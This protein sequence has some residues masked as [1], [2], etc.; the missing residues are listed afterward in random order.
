MFKMRKYLLLAMALLAMS[1]SWAQ[2]S[3]AIEWPSEGYYTTGD[4]YLVP[5]DTAVRFRALP[6]TGAE[7]WQW[8]LPG[9][10]PSVVEA[11][12][13]EVV[14]TEEGTFDVSLEALVGGTQRQ[15]SVE[16]GIQAGGANYVWNISP[17]ETATLETISLAWFGFYGGTNSLGMEKFAEFFHAPLQPALIDSV[18][19]R[20]GAN[21]VA[22]ANA[23]LTLSIAAA[24][25]KG[26]PG[27]TL[28]ATML[29]AADINKQLGKPTFFRFDQP[30]RVDGPFFV[31]IEG[32]PNA[33]GDGV[34]I[35]CVRREVGQ[36]CTAFHLLA[37]EDIHYQPMGTFTWY[38]NVDD[39]TSLA[40]CPWLRY[41]EVSSV[42]NRVGGMTAQCTFDGASLRVPVATAHL[43]VFNAAGLKVL[44]LDNPPASI[45]LASLPSGTYL[46]R[47]DGLTLKIRR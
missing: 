43:D 8:N 25:E 44:S 7:G 31:V 13:A 3:L 10:T 24:D 46:V 11:Q 22:T 5:L 41:E 23:E 30:V 12:E 15:V 29:L 40:I 16:Q 18:A 45:S 47:A 20:F 26:M 21:D 33:Y 34:A 28:G 4:T 14:Y 39:P 1:A 42:S 36:T 27:E 35:Q 9:A 32:F 6:A 37:D 38:Q 17:A 2:S 19:V